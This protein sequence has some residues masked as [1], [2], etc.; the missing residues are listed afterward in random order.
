MVL[1]VDAVG[2]VRDWEDK[3]VP[4]LRLYTEDRQRREQ[5]K[6]SRVSTG[7]SRVPT[8]DSSAKQCEHATPAVT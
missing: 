7:D 6:N 8:A 1:I 2:R 3:P 4:E 5:R